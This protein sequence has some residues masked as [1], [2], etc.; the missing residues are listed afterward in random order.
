MDEILKKQ[1]RAVTFGRYILRIFFL[2]CQPRRIDFT[3]RLLAE[4]GAS[5]SL[6]FFNRFE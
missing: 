6:K 4:T 2:Y 5:T 1:K 3:Q